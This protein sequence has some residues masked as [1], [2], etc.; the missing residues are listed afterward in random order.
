M[1]PD[2]DDR[3]TACN[4]RNELVMW[5]EFVDCGTPT[6]TTQTCGYLNHS[7]DC[8]LCDGRQAAGEAIYVWTESTTS[9]DDPWGGYPV[10]GS[11][12]V[13]GGSP[14]VIG[15]SP[16]GD[17]SIIDPQPVIISQPSI[18]YRYPSMNHRYAPASHHWRYRDP[19]RALV[20]QAN[21][22]TGQWFV[23]ARGRTRAPARA[24]YARARDHVRAHARAR[25]VAPR[26]SIPRSRV[27]T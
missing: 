16:I 25:H 26:S 8:G 27:G 10:G 20:N 7:I 14:I 19:R 18:S 21:P 22:R 12:I 6:A 23:S 4:A 13:T 9:M 15:G 24:H 5:T 2:N 17:R 1:A 11:S 3:P